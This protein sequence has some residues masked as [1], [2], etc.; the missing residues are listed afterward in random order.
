MENDVKTLEKIKK[1]GYNKK[2]RS[3]NPDYSKTYMK[4]YRKEG[5]DYY[6]KLKCKNQQKRW[7]ETE[8]GKEFRKLSTQ[9]YLNRKKQIISE[10]N[11][12]VGYP[13]YIKWK[14]IKYNGRYLVSD[15]GQ[16]FDSKYSTLVRPEIKKDAVYIPLLTD[17]K[18]KLFKLHIIMGDTFLKKT[19][20]KGWVEHIDGDKFNNI[21]SNLIWIVP[22][23]KLLSSQ[24]YKDLKSVGFSFHHYVRKIKKKL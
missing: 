20:K 9:A 22:L 7:R 1:E 11:D 14:C 8:R 2:W 15:T 21:I 23:K 24:L 3:M 12:I 13:S 19:N 5:R 4:K 10:V 18:Y 16:I 17:K 6:S